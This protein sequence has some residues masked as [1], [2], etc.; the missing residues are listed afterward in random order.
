VSHYPAED[1][2]LRASSLDKR[3]GGNVPNTLEVLEQLIKAGHCHGFKRPILVSVLP[4]QA[5]TATRQIWQSLGP[6]IN[7]DFCLHRE[8]AQEAP[9]SYIIRSQ[10][11]DSRTIINYNGLQEMTVEEFAQM[12][13]RLEPMDVGLY[14]FE[15]SISK[16]GRLFLTGFQGTNPRGDAR[17]HA[18]PPTNPAKYSNKR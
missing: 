18:I 5:S 12:A 16:N 6:G 8:D 9:A 13:D 2:K 1:E 17:V 4:A 14:H 7:C 3:R 10:T 15:V 11:S